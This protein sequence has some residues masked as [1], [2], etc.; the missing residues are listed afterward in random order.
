MIEVWAHPVLSAVAALAPDAHLVG[1]CV[2]DLLLECGA[3]ADWDFVVP[4][5]AMALAREVA[6][7]CGGS[8]VPLDA[9]RGISRAVVGGEGFDFADYQ[10]GSLE[11][12]LRARDFTVNAMALGRDG[13]LVDPT[14]GRADLGRRLL[15]CP[16]PAVL[17]ADPLRVLRAFRFAAVLDFRLSEETLDALPARAPRLSAVSGERVR[18]EWFK[19]LETDRIPL[20]LDALRDSGVLA[21]VF[22]EVEA[23]RGLEQRGF[24]HLDAYH[25]S[26]LALR[27]VDEQAYDEAIS[28][29]DF[30]DALEGHLGRM[31]P[32]GVTRRAMLRLCALLHD[33]G[34]RV[35]QSVDADTGR[36]S[37]RGHDKAGTPL[38]DAVGERLRLSRLAIRLLHKSVRWHLRPLDLPEVG[39]LKARH[40]R[41]YFRDAGD[42]GV[43][44]LVLSLADSAASGGPSNTPQVREALRR[45][46][47]W[48]LDWYFGDGR[49]QCVPLVRGDE[50]AALLGV[51]PGPRVGKLL[52]RLLDA[53]VDGRVRDR[54]EAERYLKRIIP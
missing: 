48:M 53:Q 8:L 37:Y 13:A 41:H 1:G 14:G 31:L 39:R 25:H 34:K 28:V 42:A 35:T 33:V 10:G 23:L 24:H 45:R 54:E 4:R 22:P 27:K 15:R 7:R 12:D 43:E 30:S 3:H 29:T 17:D 11:D 44:T 46:V 18:D 40:V 21:A 36:I 49:R 38:A 5:G 32:G 9:E 47:G 2:R 50:A 52:E 19:L 51:P 6:D 20:L 16:S 26:L